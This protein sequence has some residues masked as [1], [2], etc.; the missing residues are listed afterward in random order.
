[1]QSGSGA[2][3]PQSHWP[4]AYAVGPQ[5]QAAGVTGRPL[6]PLPEEPPLL[7]PPLP[8][9]P[10]AVMPPLL[11]LPITP[12]EPPLAVAPDAPPVADAGEPP[13]LE[14]PAQAASS[15]P[16]GKTATRSRGR[17]ARPTISSYP[18]PWGERRGRFRRR[19]CIP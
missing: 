1:M 15:T 8:W 19:E 3:Q 14:H 5:V 10:V 13:P 11:L 16:T 4:S 18:E 12:P 6:P 17:E 9:P 7:A 2:P